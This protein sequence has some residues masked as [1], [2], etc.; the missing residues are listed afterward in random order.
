MDSLDGLPADAVMQILELLPAEKLAGVERQRKFS[1]LPDTSHLWRLLF[2]ERGLRVDE[3]LHQCAWSTRARALGRS[4]PPDEQQPDQWKSAVLHHLLQTAL[5]AYT[6]ETHAAL[7]ALAADGSTHI[8]AASLQPRLLEESLL[9]PLMQAL[10]HLRFLDLSGCHSLAAHLPLLVDML[11]CKTAALPA[12]VGLRVADCALT[13]VELVRLVTP[14]PPRLELLDVSNNHL[15]AKSLPALKTLLSGALSHL[16]VAGHTFDQAELS[17]F[18]AAALVAP[19]L[20]LLDLGDTPCVVPRLT[21][22]QWARVRSSSAMQ[23]LF[24]NDTHI[25]EN[26]EAFAALCAHLPPRLDH[27]S[28]RST[29]LRAAHVQAMSQHSASW[30]ALVSL[31]IADNYLNRDT[32]PFLDTLLQSSTGL[33][34]CVAPQ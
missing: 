7:M 21:A 16:S 19:R 13:D 5:D 30:P 2:H 1:D 31:D 12:I 8:K 15:T 6:E 14:V 27:L 18:F 25:A 24:L 20:K 11:Q 23:Q 34:S 26:L 22:E 28:M 4:L 33:T 29:G 17:D 10:P 3:W 9:M 32:A